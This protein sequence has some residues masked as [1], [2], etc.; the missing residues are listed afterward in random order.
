M[1]I[2]AH[3][4][5]LSYPRSNFLDY[6]VLQSKCTALHFACAQGRTQLAL[7]IADKLSGIAGYAGFNTK[8]KVRY[9]PRK[10][11]T[12]LLVFTCVTTV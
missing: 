1:E 2:E 3:N 6:F 8:T 5:V 4:P 9:L 12:S 11:D 10:D 7:Q